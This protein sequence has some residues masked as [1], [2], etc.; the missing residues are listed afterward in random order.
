MKELPKCDVEGCEKNAR[1]LKGGYCQMHD[2][3]LRNHGDVNVNLYENRAKAVWE[4]P[5]G[6]FIYGQKNIDKLNL[7]IKRVKNARLLGYL[8]GPPRSENDLTLEVIEKIVD[9]YHGT[10]KTGKQ[11][12][13]RRR[14]ISTLRFARHL[15]ILV[16]SDKDSNY[17]LITIE[18][19]IWVSKVVEELVTRD[20]PAE[21]YAIVD[22][23]KIVEEH[24]K[25]LIEIFEKFP[26]IG[27]TYNPDNHT[28]KFSKTVGQFNDEFSKESNFG[29]T[30]DN[31]YL[32]DA[33]FHYKRNKSLIE[34][35]KF[36]S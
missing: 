20:K 18:E 11:K 10:Y 15:E 6:S 13:E 8:Q 26:I 3:R 17:G 2:T 21:I 24:V 12:N 1:S 31:N 32:V 34:C 7:I 16:E 25:R 33:G 5:D 22:D 28:I 23:S 35:H 36:K 14:G 19:A 4:L 27:I 30:V 29:T 9:H